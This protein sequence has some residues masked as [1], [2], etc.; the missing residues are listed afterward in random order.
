MEANGVGL[1][2]NRFEKHSCVGRSV[3]K[4]QL[5]TAAIRK[6]TNTVDNFVVVRGPRGDNNTQLQQMLKK[7]EGL[8][9]KTGKVNK[10]IIGKAGLVEHPMAHFRII[11]NY[12]KAVANGDAG[13]CYKVEV[14]TL[15]DV[16]VQFLRLFCSPS[17]CNAPS[18]TS[19]AWCR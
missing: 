8:D 4:R 12:M 7:D 15:L 13:G 18:G 9:M 1:R 17:G 6:I 11:R 5:K 14:T 3:R 10:I 2:I 16:Q 19:T